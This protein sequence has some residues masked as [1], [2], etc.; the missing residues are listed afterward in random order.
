MAHHVLVEHAH[1][2]FGDRTNPQL[3]VARRANLAH[4]EHV[5]RRAER[6]GDLV[7]DRHAAACQPDHDWVFCGERPQAIGQ[8]SAG[9]AA[10][11]ESAGDRFQHHSLHRYGFRRSPVPAKL[12]RD[13]GAPT[14]TAIRSPTRGSG[15]RFHASDWIPGQ[16]RC[17]S[18]IIASTN[19]GSPSRQEAAGA[20]DHIRTLSCARRR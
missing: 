16:H 8:L 10:V 2:A 15:D 4:D 17:R 1:V 18:R 20:G 14:R 7:G 19:Y 5:E 3:R 12:R 11:G 6:V 9:I 13:F